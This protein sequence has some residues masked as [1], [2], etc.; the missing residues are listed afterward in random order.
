[1]LLGQSNEQLSL[2]GILDHTHT[3][4]NIIRTEEWVINYPRYDDAEKCARTIQVNQ[5]D[6]DEIEASGFTREESKTVAAPRIAESSYILECRLLWDKPLDESSPWHL[7]C[8]KVQHVAIDDKAIP[9]EQS[10]RMSNLK[11][12]YN[13]RGTINPLN[14]EYCSPNVIGLLNRVVDF[15]AANE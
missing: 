6:T 10:E 1:M 12:M 13:I 11:L 5:E 8:G 14:G 15:P 3:Y 7:L 2:L 4:S 9:I